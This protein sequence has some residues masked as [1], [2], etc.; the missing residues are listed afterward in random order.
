MST[1]KPAE[2]LSAISDD[3]V[4]DVYFESVDH[5]TGIREDDAVASAVSLIHSFSDQGIGI[6]LSPAEIALMKVSS[7]DSWTPAQ[8]ADAE[9]EVRR[10]LLPAVLYDRG[11]DARRL[12]GTLVMPLNCD[13]GD[14]QTD[15]EYIA[16]IGL[17]GTV[18]GSKVGRFGAFRIQPG[19]VDR[20]GVIHQIRLNDRGYLD[21]RSIHAGMLEG[22]VKGYK[23]LEDAIDDADAIR[24]ALT[25]LRNASRAPIAEEERDFRDTPQRNAGF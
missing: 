1:L 2:G 14:H 7:R 25:T 22:F 19:C 10:A 17:D 4:E 20:R 6:Q 3:L 8:L 21:S 13:S 9:Y 12:E 11:R 18:A 16:F 24:A 23:H 5:G 15:C